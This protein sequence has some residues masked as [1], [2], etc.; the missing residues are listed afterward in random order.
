[1]SGFW[2]AT[3]LVHR[4]NHTQFTRECNISRNHILGREIVKRIPYEPGVQISGLYPGL[5]VTEIDGIDY[6]FDI[7]FYVNELNDYIIING[8]Y[9]ATIR[10]YTKNS[11]LNL[12]A[13]S[14]DNLAQQ[15]TLDHTIQDYFDML[16]ISGHS[17]LTKTSV[18]PTDPAKLVSISNVTFNSGMDNPTDMDDINAPLTIDLKIILR[19][20]L[21]G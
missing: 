16:V 8:P 7:P 21:M 5:Y 9:D 6:Y 14:G 12:Y 20:Y 2:N 11:L 1:M 17:E 19:V 15:T 10:L 3:E 13:Q 4:N 18:S